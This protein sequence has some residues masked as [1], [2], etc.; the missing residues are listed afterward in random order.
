M[1]IVVKINAGKDFEKVSE[2]LHQAVLADVVELNFKSDPKNFP[3]KPSPY[4]AR[5]E[6]RFVYVVNEKDS[7]GRYKLA[8]ERFG[9]SYYKGDTKLAKRVRNLTSLT[10]NLETLDLETLI[11][12]QRKLAIEHN[13]DKTDPNTVWANIQSVMKPDPGQN[14]QIPS[15]F[16]RAKDK[17]AKTAYMSGQRPADRERQVVARQDVG[18]FR[19]VLTDDDIPF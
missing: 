16:V 2:G 8:F 19:D 5:D 15:D 13:L 17:P 1:P 9:R 10:V 18:N 4:A 14:I 11:G 7:E 3:S 12:T 6:I